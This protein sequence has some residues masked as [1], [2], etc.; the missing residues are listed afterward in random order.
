MHSQNRT[1]QDSIALIK[2]Y[3]GFLVSMLN[4]VINTVGTRHAYSL[5]TYRD[6]ET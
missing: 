2:L 6:N 1:I 4:D 5:Y 3:L